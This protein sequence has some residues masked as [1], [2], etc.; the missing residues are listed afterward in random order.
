[1]AALRCSL[2]SFFVNCPKDNRARTKMAVWANSFAPI[3]MYE[4]YCRLHKSVSFCNDNLKKKILKS[5]L[6]N[7]LTEQLSDRN[8]KQTCKHR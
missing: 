1:M 2:V 4:N 3:K 6:L 8:C 5:N 7:S